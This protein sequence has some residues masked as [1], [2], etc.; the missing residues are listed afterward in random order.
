M[1]KTSLNSI[2]PNLWAP[3]AGILQGLTVLQQCVYQMK[4]RN[5]CIVKKRL[6]QPHLRSAL[7]S[8]H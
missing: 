3:T 2:C 1:K 5:V 6:V 7:R 8:S 4:L